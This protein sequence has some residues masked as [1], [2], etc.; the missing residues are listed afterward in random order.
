MNRITTTKRA[1][2]ILATLMLDACDREPTYPSNAAAAYAR[3]CA[4]CHGA[5]G[6][7]DGPAAAALVPPPTN[8]TRSTLDLADLM[9]V[10]DGRRTVRAHG[11]GTMPV[12]G[13]VFEAEDEN[14]DRRH[15]DALRRVQG[16]AEYVRALAAAAP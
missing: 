16:L 1:A 4:S 15:R 5:T 7:G 6:G 13:F 3:Y 9:R 14:S 2:L 10:I 11:T 8:L 12:W